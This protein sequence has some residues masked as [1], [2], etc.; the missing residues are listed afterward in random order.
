MELVS[1]NKGA[2]VSYFMMIQIV[3]NIC[4]VESDIVT[5]KQHPQLKLQNNQQCSRVVTK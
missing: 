3:Q 1:N 4:N 5:A 2:K